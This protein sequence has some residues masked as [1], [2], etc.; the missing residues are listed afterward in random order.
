MSEKFSYLSIDENEDAKNPPE[1]ISFK[2]E[3]YEQVK[4]LLEKKY[5]INLTLDVD[6]Q[7]QLLLFLESI[8]S[9]DVDK[10]K[11]LIDLFGKD[12]VIILLGT[13]NHALQVDKLFTISRIYPSQIIRSLFQEIAALIEQG[14]H[15]STDMRDRLQVDSD[16]KEK[17][18][19]TIMHRVSTKVL[20]IL[21]QFSDESNIL[22]YDDAVRIIK[23]IDSQQIIISEALSVARSSEH[24]KES[25]SD[26]DYEISDF[27]GKELDN[28]VK[29]R[30]LEIMYNNYSHKPELRKALLRRLSSRF[31]D[32]NTVFSILKIADRTAGFSTI[33]RITANKVE[34]A[35]FNVNTPLRG[36]GLGEIFMQARLDA[37]ARENIVVASCS[38]KEEVA[39][40][41]LKRNFIAT[42]A[43]D[44]EGEPSLNIVR[45]DNAQDL[46]ISKRLS[47]QDIV[48]SPPEYLARHRI[49]R[50]RFLLKD[51]DPTT[52]IGEKIR[53]GYVLTRMIKDPKDGSVVYAVFEQVS[54]ENLRRYSEEFNPVDLEE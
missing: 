20:S 19:G 16:E 25:T 39:I 42:S 2:I 15:I 3:H 7:E 46:F 12:V 32:Q 11:E 51:T 49:I 5:G 29:T 40:N 34:F 9:I 4:I 50:E 35:S 43:F 17:I 23:H 6:I 48:T 53:E 8:E 22:D 47:G 30:L 36:A 54:S 18:S 41:Y 27:H 33:T 52:L 13:K 1:A 44:Y 26:E 21:D 24:Y 14:I 31:D 10:C 45:N 38:A 28:T 37:F